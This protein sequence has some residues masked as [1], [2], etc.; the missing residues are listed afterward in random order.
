MAVRLLLLGDRD[1]VLGRIG[2][3][4][5]VPGHDRLLAR[6]VEVDRSAVPA[7]A[8]LEAWPPGCSAGSGCA[9]PLNASQSA[10]LIRSRFAAPACGHWNGFENGS[11]SWTG[12]YGCMSNSLKIG[13]V[14]PDA[15]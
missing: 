10:C 6:F 2:V 13:V 1:H 15:L 4:G 3:G 12:G 11:A 8:D 5:L 14:R 9:V 7:G